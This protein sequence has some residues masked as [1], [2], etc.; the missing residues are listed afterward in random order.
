MGSE[1]IELTFLGG[2]FGTIVIIAFFTMYIH[3]INK[4]ELLFHGGRIHG[5]SARVLGVIGLAGLLGGVYLLVSYLVFKIEE[6]FGWPVAA[7]LFSLFVLI[8]FTLRFLSIFF[9]S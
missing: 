5:K 8:N 6:P 2:L 4:K 7:I 9:R 1:K 3:A